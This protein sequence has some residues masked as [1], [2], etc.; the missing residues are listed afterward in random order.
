MKQIYLIK[1]LYLKWILKPLFPMYWMT[2]G[3]G[4]GD[5]LYYVKVNCKTKEEVVNIIKIFEKLNIDKRR[6]V[7]SA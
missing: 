7:I 6:I 5:K 3:R 2:W 1:M 4:G